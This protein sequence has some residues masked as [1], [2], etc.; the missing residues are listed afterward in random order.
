MQEHLPEEP[1]Y[2]TELPDD[3]RERRA[4]TARRK[5]WRRRLVTLAVLLVAAAVIAIAV[6]WLNGAI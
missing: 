3:L 5:R 6:A 2:L 1:V 4:E